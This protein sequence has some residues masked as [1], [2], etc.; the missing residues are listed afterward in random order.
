MSSFDRE[1]ERQVP[2]KE[3]HFKGK[4][5]PGQVSTK[6]GRRRIEW[7]INFAN[8]PPVVVPSD[9]LSWRFKNSTTS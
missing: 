2:A 3:S 6:F 4:M 7:Q 8:Q 1:A 5:K 9:G